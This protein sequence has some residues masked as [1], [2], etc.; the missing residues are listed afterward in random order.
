MIVLLR[1]LLH[2]KFVFLKNQNLF[3]KKPKN[4][5]FDLISTGLWELIRL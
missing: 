5:P 4:K 2:L 1:L 3:F